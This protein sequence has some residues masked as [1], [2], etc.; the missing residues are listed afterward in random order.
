M[1][2]M[3]TLGL[4]VVMLFGFRYRERAFSSLDL[5]HRDNPSI[6]AMPY[7]LPR[8]EIPAVYRALAHQRCVRLHDSLERDRVRGSA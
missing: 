3:Y 5:R 6:Y 4:V 1:G 2:P 7:P 8:R